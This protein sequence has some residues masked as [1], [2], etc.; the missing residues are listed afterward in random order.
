MGNEQG[1][2]KPRIDPGLEKKL[3]PTASRLDLK[4]KNIYNFHFSLVDTTHYTNVTWLN[5]PNN[6]LDSFPP[7]LYEVTTLKTLRLSANK[8]A[9][10][11]PDLKKLSSLTV[12]DIS[13]NDF[14]HISDDFGYLVA[15]VDLNA[16]WNDIT[17]VRSDF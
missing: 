15:L 6:F 1:R 14:R 2:G 17:L 13:K 16:H 9:E 7:S 11:S 3:D 12:L 8:V 10:V 4:T 5:L